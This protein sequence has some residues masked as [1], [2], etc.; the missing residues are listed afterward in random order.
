MLDNMRMSLNFPSIVSCC[1]STYSEYPET[2]KPL[3]IESSVTHHSCNVSQPPACPLHCSCL[4][5]Y[6][7]EHRFK[8]RAWGSK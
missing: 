3:L 7:L 4:C 6:V 5:V 1:L 8:S 2:A